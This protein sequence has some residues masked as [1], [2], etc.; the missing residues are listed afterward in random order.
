MGHYSIQQTEK[1]VEK[2]K[3]AYAQKGINMAFGATVN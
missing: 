2:G 1:Y 3:G